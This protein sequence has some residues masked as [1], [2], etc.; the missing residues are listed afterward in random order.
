MHRTLTYSV[1][2]LAGIGLLLTTPTLRSRQGEAKP[3]YLQVHIPADAE[4][5]VDGTRT[6]QQGELR[7]FVSPPLAPGQNF[8]YTFRA[9]WKDGGKEVTRERKVRVQA[10]TET[11]V[12]LRQPDES[13]EIK[14]AKPVESKPAESKPVASNP[15]TS[16]PPSDDDKAERTPDVIFVPTPQE[17][18]DKMLE[19]AQV[20]KGDVLYDL[21]CGDGRIV[22]TAAKKYQ[23]KAT[24]YDIDP[25]RVRESMDNVKKNHVEDL[26][27]I[28]KADIFTLDLKDA[29]VITLYLLPDLNVKLMPQLEKLKPGSHIVSHDFPMRGAKPKEVVHMKAKNDN[30]VEGDHTIYLWVVPWEKEE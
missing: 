8:F 27:T 6:K 25:Q 30:G 10:G 2:L 15:P 14:E 28:K 26:A 9:T 7:K 18:V 19:M 21:G 13:K 1:F 24:G 16:T 20:K 29:N 17:V 12:D 4:L 5:T 11:T 3:A 23:A 22:V